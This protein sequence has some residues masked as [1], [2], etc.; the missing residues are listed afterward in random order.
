LNLPNKITISR[1][2]VVPLFIF[3]AIPMADSFA[4]FLHITSF[5]EFLKT[6]GMF[7][8]A[9]IFILASITDLLDGY[10]ARRNRQITKLGIFMDP[11]ADKL[12]VTAALV[13][14]VS[15]DLLSVWIAI[16]IIAR[17]FLVT[18]LRI[19]AV[20][21]GIVIA[22]SN[23]AK[24]K[25]ASQ[26]VAISMMLLNNFPFSLFTTINIASYV[27]LFALAITIFSGYDYFR[28]NINVLISK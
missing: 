3:F 2:I 19:V 10:L 20:G 1:I 16:I 21:D 24:L 22:A 28:K 4:A 23:W 5:N 6:S 9:V 15:R 13:C 12:L 27:M 26:I 11:I 25:T 17:E 7:I 8:S 18:G 14:L